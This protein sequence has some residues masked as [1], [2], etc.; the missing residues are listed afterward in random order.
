MYWLCVCL[1][2]CLSAVP[3]TVQA[4]LLYTVDQNAFDG[5][6]SSFH[7]LLLTFTRE[8]WNYLTSHFAALD[9]LRLFTSPSKLLHPTSVCKT[10][11]I[12]VCVCVYDAMGL[13]LFPVLWDSSQTGHKY[14]GASVWGSH[15]HTLAHTHKCTVLA[16]GRA[17]AFFSPDNA[18]TSQWEP[19]SLW[20]LGQLDLH[21][22]EY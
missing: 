12:S 10:V 3:S 4:R 19:A 16:T 11:D 2:P 13:V 9:L 18:D 21:I 14:T 17:L 20:Q 15:A 22:H 8:F 1:S 7:S 5:H 6:T